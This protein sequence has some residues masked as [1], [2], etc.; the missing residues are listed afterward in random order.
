[1]YRAFFM[2]QMLLAFLFLLPSL[3]GAATQANNLPFLPHFTRIELDEGLSHATV[4]VIFQ[5][6][7]GYIW[8]GTGNGLNRYDGI[9][10]KTYHNDPKNANSLSS[11]NI[12]A[13]VED[14]DG[15]LW[16]GTWG[17][18]LNNFNPHTN[19]VKAYRWSE[20][21]EDT[22]SNDFIHSIYQDGENLWIGTRNGLNLFNKKT[23][24][25]K[26]YLHKEN[27]Q[28]PIPSGRIS[29]IRSGGHSSLWLGTDAGLVRFFPETESFERA[30]AWGSLD[31]GHA[32]IIDVLKDKKNRLWVVTSRRLLLWDP[33]TEGYSEIYPAKL[34]ESSDYATRVYQDYNGVIWWGSIYNGLWMYKDG[35]TR[36][37]RHNPNDT[38][39]INN[40]HV[41]ALYADNSGNLW[42]ATQ[43]AGLNRLNLNPPNFDHHFHVAGEGFPN[44]A[45]HQIISESPDV[46]WMATSRMGMTRWDRK[47]N[48]FKSY[49]HSPEDRKSLSDNG[50][51]CLAIDRDGVLWAGTFG[52]LNRLEKDGSFTHF[53]PDPENH[54]SLVHDDVFSL[55]VDRNN[56]LWIGS[57][58]GLSRFDG[59]N[60]INDVR[61]KQKGSIGQ[62]Q[63]ECIFEDSKGTVW[64]GLN[65][66]GLNRH[67][68]STDQFKIYSP[69]HHIK[70][71]SISDDKII[72]IT[73]T[74]EGLW[75]GTFGRGLN[76]MD[77]NTESFTQFLQQDGLP[78][79]VITAIV[80][81]GKGSLW[82]STF[83]GL[84]HMIISEQKFINY[85][86]LDGL[87]SNQFSKNSALRMDS[88]E[89]LF[90]GVKGL[91]SFFPERIAVGSF[92]PHVVI[93]GLKIR[94]KPIPHQLMN[95]SVEILEPDENFIEFEFAS[96][97][98]TR[99]QKNHFRY[100]L[101]NI[102]PH[103]IDS[104]RPFVFYT[105]LSSGKYS[106]RVK[107]T[108]HDGIWSPEETVVTLTIKTP[109][110]KTGWAYAFYITFILLSL[111]GFFLFQKR[112][113]RLRSEVQ[114]LTESQKMAVEANRAKSAFLAHMSHELRT[115][116][117]VI[118]GYAEML[119]EDLPDL[120]DQSSNALA[121]I[122]DLKK[123]RSAAQYQVTLINNLLELTKIES[124]G[125]ELYIESFALREM[126]E[127]ITDNMQSQLGKNKNKLILDLPE[128]GDIPM[129]ADFSKVN[130]VLYNII[131]NA[132]KYT[133]N[134][135]ITVQVRQFEKNSV[136]HT[137][138][139]IEDTGCGISE[140]QQTRIFQ[141]FAMAGTQAE[142]SGLGL[143]LTKNFVE[144]MSGEIQ[145]E[146][147][148]GKGSVV[149]VLLP[150]VVSKK[151][152][153]V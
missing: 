11:D 129:V 32:R 13:I 151:G 111:V 115:P 135:T 93:T 81:D 144:A 106:F 66:G 42:A 2:A 91:N 37:F 46:I 51:N 71:G 80:P 30:A 35:E 54:N 83:K 90:G 26:R 118:I 44:S 47:N 94:G 84:S 64:L 128:D 145:I 15:S 140:E 123:I 59:Q 21:R 48:V 105:G 12:A 33:A 78:N 108:N 23:K 61:T 88:G 5:D 152:K 153:E 74:V 52:G 20:E 57:K 134:G 27:E 89:I 113:E 69:S 136:G 103:W 82:I 143:F 72:C 95:G 19:E 100:K 62:G 102:D 131:G 34:A 16:V 43:S 116:L 28:S 77:P 7:M 101:D 109:L 79:N 29:V 104:K 17:G 65:D 73:E 14:E 139:K 85:D 147:V 107:G 110:Y 39:S 18:G 124:G 38:L 112:Q 40:D 50:V 92:Q 96:L 3:L 25:V 58:D 98:Y 121:P 9:R 122:S 138:F 126:I 127:Q 149:T 148:L 87:Q 56:L 125:I 114:I 31:L 86:F 137:I 24:V 117:N 55:M 41:R 133:E 60:F 45:I 75:I 76:L 6:S 67:M 4:F 146:S 1:M 22:L 70:D 97:D 68:P 49:M 8:F 141:K 10:F 119:E 99:P 53:R 120:M 132:T 130:G 63:I 36:S 150:T 142:G